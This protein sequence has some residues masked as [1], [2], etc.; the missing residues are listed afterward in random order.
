M[1]TIY[2]LK[3]VLDKGGR[4]LIFPE[5]GRTFKAVKRGRLESPGGKEIGTL[6]NGA[7]W[8]AMKTGARILPVWLD[9]TDRILPNNR[10][11]FPRLWR[12]ATIK[13]GTPIEANGH[14]REEIT[15]EIARALLSL[16]DEGEATDKKPSAPR[17]SAPVSG[18]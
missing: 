8:L 9:G 6:K 3:D 1:S 5:G 2:G 13:I 10:F 18:V 11:P 7:G 4:V 12:H 16:A 15:A 17:R 14:K